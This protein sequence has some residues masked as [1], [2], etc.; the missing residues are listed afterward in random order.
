MQLLLFHAAVALL[1]PL[2]YDLIGCLSLSQSG[3][4]AKD[5]CLKV[6]SI[7]T[8]GA[9][10]ITAKHL[11]AMAKELGESMQEEDLQEWIDEAD[12]DGDGMVNETEFLRVMKKGGINIP[13][14]YDD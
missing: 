6:F 13:L 7:I 4:N 8:D 1:L 3:G 9:H 10:N 12:D 14:T 5:E 11:A 2:P